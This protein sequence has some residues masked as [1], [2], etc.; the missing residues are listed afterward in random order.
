MVI[1]D[2]V[3]DFGNHP[4]VLAVGGRPTAE[5]CEHPKGRRDAKNPQLCRACGG[6]VP[7]GVK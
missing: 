3:Q 4:G 6:P 5:D 7:D 2:E 1:V